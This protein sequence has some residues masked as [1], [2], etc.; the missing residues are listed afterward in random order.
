MSTVHEISESNFDVVVDGSDSLFLVE[1]WGS[2]CGPCKTMLTLL[3][4]LA[5]DEAIPF[6]VGKIEIGQNPQL[7]SRFGV[8]TVPTFITFQNGEPVARHSGAASRTDLVSL[9]DVR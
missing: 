2:W 1:F 4:G 5:K 8:M 3:E 7:A 9:V 6:S